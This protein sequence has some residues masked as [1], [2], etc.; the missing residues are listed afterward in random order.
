MQKSVIALSPSR[1]QP[2]PSVSLPACSAAPPG[3][4]LEKTLSPSPPGCPAPMPVGPRGPAALGPALLSAG[5]QTKPL[6]AGDRPGW[7]SSAE[8]CGARQ[9]ARGG[10]DGT[11]PLGLTDLLLPEA[12]LMAL[13]LAAVALLLQVWTCLLAPLLSAKGKTAIRA[14]PLSRAS[15]R[16]GPGQEVTPNPPNTAPKPQEAARDP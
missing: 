9:L 16:G 8:L 10:T 15:A 1:E 13:S 12:V 3:R 6:L 2:S 11:V 14:H 5:G 4:I 7:G